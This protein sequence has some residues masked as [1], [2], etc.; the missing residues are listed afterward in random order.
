MFEEESAVITQSPDSEDK[1]SRLFVCTFIFL[2]ARQSFA[3]TKAFL[4]V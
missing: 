1:L 4:I 3:A 2:T